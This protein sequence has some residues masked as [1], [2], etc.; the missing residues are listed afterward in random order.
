VITQTIPVP[1]PELSSLA[2]RI[3][4]LQVNP[5]K[6]GSIIGPQGKTINEITKVTGV[7]I[8]IEDTGQVYVTAPSQ[9]SADKA[10]AWIKDLTREL[11]AGE[12]FEA[13][14]VRLVDFGAFLEVVPGQD[15]LL[16]ISEF[17]PG[18]HVQNPSDVLK[19]GQIVRVRIEAIDAQG[20]VDLELADPHEFDAI[21]DKFPL[22]SSNGFRPHGGRNFGGRRFSR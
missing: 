5:E 9:D 20:R 17:V 13:K 7:T 15:G 1:R 16:H 14:V 3:I 10:I 18:H 6:I 8:D 4:T 19:L 12:E 21:K 2:P 11:K 22:A